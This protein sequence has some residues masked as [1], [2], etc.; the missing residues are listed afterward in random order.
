MKRSLEETEFDVSD[1]QVTK[2]AKI[3]GVMTEVSPMKE[4]KS[5]KLKYF[6]GKICDG[7]SSARFVCFDKKMHEKLSSICEKK[8]H[9][10]LS[11]CEVKKSKFCTGFEVIVRNT[12]E[13]HSSPKKNRCSR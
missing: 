4:S 8:K 9:L 1:M 6:N 10:M 3:H 5:G 7:K 2:H 11:N 13:V 12:S